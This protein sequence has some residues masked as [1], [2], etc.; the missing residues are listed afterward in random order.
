MTS[1]YPSYIEILF[2]HYTKELN[3]DLTYYLP[4]KIQCASTNII[5]V[6]EQKDFTLIISKLSVGVAKNRWEI[7]QIGGAYNELLKKGI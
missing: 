1:A 6:T 7:R 2:N 5:E 3:L 4:M